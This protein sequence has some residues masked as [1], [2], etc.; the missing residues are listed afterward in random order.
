ML[1]TLFQKAVMFT[2]VTTTPSGIANATLHE[3]IMRL[4]AEV[5]KEWEVEVSSATTINEVCIAQSVDEVKAL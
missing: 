3:S 2:Q 1:I 5:G 4:P